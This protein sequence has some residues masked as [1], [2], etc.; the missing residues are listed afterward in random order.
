[1]ITDNYG[2]KIEAKVASKGPIKPDNP[3]IID[4]NSP[5][6][7]GISVLQNSR[8]VGRLAGEKGQITIEATDLGSGPVRLHVIGLGQGGPRTHVLA[9]PIDVSVESSEQKNPIIN[10]N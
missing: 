2:R 9:L 5:G 1:M 8:I 3:L 4:V 6:S 10:L 7:I